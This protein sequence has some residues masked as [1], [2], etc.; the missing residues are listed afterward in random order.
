MIEINKLDEENMRYE[1]KFLISGV[2]IQQIIHILKNSPLLF[3]EM[4]YERQ[5]NNIY[6]DYIDLKNLKDNL[7]GNQRRIKVRIRW[8][9]QTFGEISNP[10]LEIKIKNS[11][12][13]KKL[14]FSLEEFKLDKEFSYEEIV[15]CLQKSKLPEWVKEKMRAYQAV[16]INSYTRKYFLSFNKQC[17]L[18]LDSKQR[19]TSINKNKNNFIRQEKDSNSVVLEIKYSDKAINS[20]VNFVEHIPFRLGRN[21][22]YVN[23]MNLLDEY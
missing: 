7:E 21:S 22:K 3:K 17:R 19:F 9:G 23:G 5:V 1:K 6:F 20:V 10:V 2:E 8:Y 12:K 15:R 18:T 11:D 13:G 14:I 16:M 4:Y